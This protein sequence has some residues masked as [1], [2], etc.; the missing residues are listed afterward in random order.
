[1]V[2]YDIQD[3]L[4]ESY[5][6]DRSRD[7]ATGDPLDVKP[8]DFTGMLDELLKDKENTPRPPA[9]PA[10]D[11]NKLNLDVRKLV[12]LD[13]GEEEVKIDERGQIIR[14]VPINLNPVPT[15]PPNLEERYAKSRH[16]TPAP[17]LSQTREINAP[18]EFPGRPYKDEMYGRLHLGPEYPSLHK[19]AEKPDISFKE[20]Q[21]VTNKINQLITEA[22]KRQNYYDGPLNE[23]KKI[24]KLAVALPIPQSE[25]DLSEQP[26]SPPFTDESPNDGDTDTNLDEI[27]K[28]DESELL[29]KNPLDKKDEPEEKGNWFQKRLKKAFKYIKGEAKDFKEYLPGKRKEIWAL[30]AFAGLAGFT[31]VLSGAYAA[32]IAMAAL[33]GPAGIITG[34]AVGGLINYFGFSKTVESWAKE[35]QTEEL[36]KFNPE[37]GLDEN[38]YKEKVARDYKGRIRAFAIA[39]I[40]AKIAAGIGLG[41]ILTPHHAEPTTPGQTA[42]VNPDG[43]NVSPLDHANTPPGAEP[44]STAPP[45]EIIPHEFVKHVVTDKD[46][47]DSLLGE[48][49]VYSPKFIDILHQNHDSIMNM[50]TKWAENNGHHGIPIETG[51]DSHMEYKSIEEVGKLLDKV[52]QEGYP[53]AATPPAQAAEMIAN[54]ERINQWILPGTVVELPTP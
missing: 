52:I 22:H 5:A 36:G 44:I 46:T 42:P 34:I 41:H 51:A 23:R 28:I 49:V 32:Q 16:D 8:V 45:P 21:Q 53:T 3:W 17:E 47:W 50:F 24:K 14:K 2:N 12:P 31:S 30:S 27:P 6:A 10:S 26:E 38:I 29:D 25:P 33:G 7:F 9:S 54:M 11:L 15:P 18:P 43:T 39:D 48:K 4:K 40:A 19:A 35:K 1:M 37:S 20:M 13:D